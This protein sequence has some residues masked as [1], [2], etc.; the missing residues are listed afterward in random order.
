MLSTPW[1]GACRGHMHFA[2]ADVPYDRLVEMDDINPHFK[3]LIWP[4]W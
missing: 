4:W 2:E 1:P 3:M